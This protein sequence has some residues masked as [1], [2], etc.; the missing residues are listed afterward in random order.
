MAH[1][2]F[3][4]PRMKKDITVYA[5]AGDNRTVPAVASLMGR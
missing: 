3:S 1:V 2:T 4:S 5:V